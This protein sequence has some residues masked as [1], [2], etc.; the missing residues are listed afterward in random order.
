[1]TVVLAG[2]VSGY[3][4]NFHRD[5]YILVPYLMRVVAC[6]KHYTANRFIYENLLYA[7][8]IVNTVEML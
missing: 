7:S 2:C 5:L 4:P 3:W 1:M 6:I 8:E